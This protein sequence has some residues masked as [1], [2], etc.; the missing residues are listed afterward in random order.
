[1][2]YVLRRI[3]SF[4][5]RIAQ[6]IAAGIVLETDGIVVLAMKLIVNLNAVSLGY[7]TGNPTV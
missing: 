2:G 7:V 5:E 6:L 1:M 4:E 3:R